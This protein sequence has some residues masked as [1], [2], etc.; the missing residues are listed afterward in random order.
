[1]PQIREYLTETYVRIE[2]FPTMFILD[3]YDGLET[4]KETCDDH[5]TDMYVVR[6]LTYITL[7]KE[8]PDL[9]GPNILKVFSYTRG[10]NLPSPELLDDIIEAKYGRRFRFFGEKDSLNTILAWQS[11]G[12]WKAGVQFL[13]FELEHDYADEGVISAAI[14][15]SENL[16]EFVSSITVQDLWLLKSSLRRITINEVLETYRSLQSRHL[17]ICV[18]E[19]LRSKYGYADIVTRYKPPYLAGKEIDVYAKKGR[20][21]ESKTVTFCECKLRFN[22]GEISLEELL[23]FIKVA[24]MVKQYESEQ[25]KKEG[26]NAKIIAWLITN[27]AI[28][29]A[30]LEILHKESIHV[31]IAKLP[32]GWHKRGDWKIIEINEV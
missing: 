25:I 20:T 17:E 5:I 19:F 28:S 8:D 30:A 18:Q 23:G 21:G 16:A 11:P 10:I 2:P 29:P 9:D 13:Q 12:I 27:A 24:S 22:D 1:M 14:E 31:M 3:N 32:L 4:T 15:F 7:E 6:G 26:G